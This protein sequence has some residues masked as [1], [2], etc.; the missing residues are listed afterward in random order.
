LYYDCATGVP[1]GITAQ[2]GSGNPYTIHA[3]VVTPTDKTFVFA[4]SRGCELVYM[5]GSYISGCAS[6]IWEHMC[7]PEGNCFVKK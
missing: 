6:S 2:D 1:T 3:F 5:K 4:I 7:L